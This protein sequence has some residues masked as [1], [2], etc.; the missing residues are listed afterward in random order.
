MTTQAENP[1]TEIIRSTCVECHD[2]GIMLTVKGP[3]RCLAHPAEFPFSEAAVRLSVRLWWMQD[4]QKAVNP[5]ALRIARFLTHATFE[6]PIQGK[7]LRDFFG[8]SRRTVSDLVEHLR[9]E[10]ALPVG[11]FRE[12]PYG[13]YW[14]RSPEEFKHWL[15]TMRAQAM[16][17][18]TTAYSLYRAVY[19]ELAGQES[20]DFADDF[21][22]DLQEAIK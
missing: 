15:R 18:L 8:L 14:M 3:V 12:P 16:T 6:R 2:T 22:R 19:P 9:T 20:L 5:L 4:Q 10:W 11:S 17:E 7:A 21:S 1:I 13:Y